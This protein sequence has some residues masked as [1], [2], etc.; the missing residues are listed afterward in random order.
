MKRH[1]LL[2]TILALTGMYARAQTTYGGG[3]LPAE[4]NGGY[5]SD[6]EPSTTV[7]PDGSV[8][9]TNNGTYEHGNTSFQNNGSW[10]SGAGGTDLFV[11]NGTNTISGS[12]APNFFN[13]QFNTGASSVMNITNAQGANVAGQLQFNNGV[14][15]TIRGVHSNSALRFGDGAS[16]TGGNSDTQHVNG[17]VTKTGTEAF[18]F[19]IGSGTDLRTLTISAPAAVAGISAAWFEGSPATVTDPSDAATHSISAFAEPVKWVSPV[20]FWDWINPA[21]T[22]DGIVITAS[23]PDMTGAFSS[24]SDLRLV[25]WDGTKWI[26]LSAGVTAT[27]LS[28]NSTVSGEIPPG[29]TITALA[30]GAVDDPLPVLL[31]SFEGKVVE[32]SSYLKWATTEE[33]NASHFEIQRSGDARNFETI[34]KIAANGESKTLMDYDFW[35]SLPLPGANYYRLRMVDLDNSY[36]FSRTIVLRFEIDERISIYPNPVADVLRIESNTP[37][38]SI[39]VF[40]VNGEKVEIGSFPEADPAKFTLKSAGEINLQGKAS[41]VYIIKVNGKSFRVVKY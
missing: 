35:D 16:Y 37:L 3:G 23:I 11:G 1:L 31:A 24:A 19:P 5:L 14:T 7:L 26:S 17:Y 13:V 21:G 41:G 27:G 38:K 8:I 12:S 9:I 2:Q 15:N 32:N 39:E 34:G 30:I 4:I 25:G 20:G 36:S 22:D 28:E 40:S 6:Y 33:V 10:N 29:S 18:T